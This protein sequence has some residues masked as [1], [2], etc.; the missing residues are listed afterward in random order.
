MQDRQDKGDLLRYRKT[1]QKLV[2]QYVPKGK[3]LDEM[4]GELAEKWNPLYETEQKRNLVEDVN[5]LGRD[6]VRPIR[7]SFRV[8]PPDSNRIHALA[9]QL[10]ASKNL[11][12]IKK[13]ELLVRYIELCVVLCLGAEQ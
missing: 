1:I 10:A 9:E 2:S 12:K 7:R 4:L 6:F 3:S 8:K 13:K 11:V 5:A